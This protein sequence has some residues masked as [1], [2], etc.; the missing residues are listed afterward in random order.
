[1]RERVSLLKRINEC[2]YISWYH[3]GANLCKLSA[4]EKH[5]LAR[6]QVT[7][8]EKVLCGRNHGLAV[9]GR[10]EVLLDSHQREGFCA[11]LFR[12]RDVTVHLGRNKIK[13]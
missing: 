7:R 3:E 1:M 6:E 9:A 10:H 2:S 4:I 11:R 13:F 8:C 5:V 12:L